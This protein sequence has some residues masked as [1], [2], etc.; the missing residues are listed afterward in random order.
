L[1][2]TVPDTPYWQPK[3]GYLGETVSAIQDL[4]QAIHTIIQ[5][6]LGS[7]PLEPEF[8]ADLLRFFAMPARL[9]A[10]GIV[11]AAARALKRWEPRI[12]TGQISCFQRPD[13]AGGPSRL[14]LRVAWAPS[15]EGAAY[16]KTE[17]AL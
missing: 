4:E 1:S 2:C 7:V 12:E 8:G 9:A 6:P 16:I 17:V 13:D 11:K 10:S 5:T 14:Y 3:P 15:G